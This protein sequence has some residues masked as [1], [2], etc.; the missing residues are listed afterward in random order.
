MMVLL[1]FVAKSVSPKA[2]ITAGQ[3]E[4]MEAGKKRLAGDTMHEANGD[5]V[6]GLRREAQHLKEVVT[7]QVLEL[8]LFK[9]G[10]SAM[11]TTKI[12]IPGYR[13]A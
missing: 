6:K 2:R 4:F 10:Y 9:K 8:H 7:D 1:S 12:E 5:E 13:E 11:G 3:R